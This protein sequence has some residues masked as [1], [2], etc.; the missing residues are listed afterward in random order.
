MTTRHV[1]STEFQTRTGLYLDEA[2]KAPIII[3][4]Y[5]RPVRVLV[6]IDEYERLKSYAT[7]KALHPHELSDDVKAALDQEFQGGPTPQPDHPLNSAVVLAPPPRL[8]IKCD[9]PWK[10]DKDAGRED[11]LSSR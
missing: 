2:G 3:T 11:R 7:R 9:F 6:D 8:V 1:T 5:N 10:E 4:R